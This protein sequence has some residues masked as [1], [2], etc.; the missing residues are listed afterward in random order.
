MSSDDGS[1][2]SHPIDPLKPLY[3]RVRPSTASDLAKRVRSAGMFLET[4]AHLPV[5]YRTSLPS[6]YAPSPTLSLEFASVSGNL[7]ARKYHAN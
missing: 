7:E 6:R 2:F 1:N 3:F 5:P 4:F